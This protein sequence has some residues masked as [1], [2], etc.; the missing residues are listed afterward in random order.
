MPYRVVGHAEDRIDAVLLDSARRWGVPAAARYHRLILAAAAAA[1]E[2]PALPGSRDI[3]RLVGVRTLHLRSVRRL[4]KV[5]DR[6]VEP[7]HLIVYRLA[8]DGVVEI[9]SIVHD[10]MQL[11]RAARSALGAATS[12][13]S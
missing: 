11:S 1:G 5:E 7:R 10:R 9:L 8:S 13:R 12:E 2:A 4:V 3:P 6:V